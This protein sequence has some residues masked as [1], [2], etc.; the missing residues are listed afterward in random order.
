MNSKYIEKYAHVL[1]EYCCKIK[2][3]DRVLIRSTPLAE[4]L[5]LACQKA[6]IQA[7]GTCEFDISL[8]GMSRQFYELSTNDQLAVAPI[9]YSHA[10]KHLM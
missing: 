4:P 8:Q 9:L 5:I 7:G 2:D 1:T 10:I 3:K 6:V